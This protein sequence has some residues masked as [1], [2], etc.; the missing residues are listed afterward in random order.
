M[1]VRALS[2]EAYA[3]LVRQPFSVFDSVSFSQINAAKVDAVY[4][5]SLATIKIGLA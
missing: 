1:E 5:L 4:Y 3:T 2:P